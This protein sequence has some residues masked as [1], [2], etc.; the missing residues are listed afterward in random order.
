MCLRLEILIIDVPD[1]VATVVMSRFR[2][3][4]DKRMCITTS[5]ASRH[6]KLLAGC[7]DVIN[8]VSEECL[9]KPLWLW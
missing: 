6:G 2:R 5:V 7:G 1:G 3:M 9:I 4:L 8:L